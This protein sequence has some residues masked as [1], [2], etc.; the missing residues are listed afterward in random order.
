M[1]FFDDLPQV[2]ELPEDEEPEQTMP[3]WFGPPEQVMGAIVPL[4]QV[5]VRTEH[6][7]IGLRSLTAYA[8]GLSIDVALAVRRAEMSR[9]RWREVQ[10]ATWGG[11]QLPGAPAAA[12]GLRWGVEL[13]DG[14]RT[15]TSNRWDWRPE[16]VPPAPVLIDTD[17]SGSGDS[18]TI[19]RSSALWLWPMPEGEALSLVVQWPDLEVPQTTYRLDLE[20]VRAAVEKVQPFW[21]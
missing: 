14:Q 7:F 12:G 19:E 4:A 16:V 10:D 20:P 8:N 5:V 11:H 9:E 21:P 13:A 3:E 6:V 17:G 1:N 2:P 18:R 15:S